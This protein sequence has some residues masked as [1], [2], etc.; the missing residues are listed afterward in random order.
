MQ[1]NPRHMAAALTLP[2]SSTIVP[3][4]LILQGN[5]AEQLSST[6][7]EF[8]ARNPLDPLEPE[9]VL[10]QSNGV[11]EWFRMAMAEHSRICAAAQVELPGRFLWRTYRQ[12]LGLQNVPAQ[13]PVDK[14]AL[15]WRLLRTLPGLVQQSDFAPLA[16]YLQPN[17]PERLWQ[18]AGRLA[19]LFDQYQ[20]YRPDWLGDWADGRNQLHSAQGKGML[21]PGEQLWQPALWRAVLGGLTQ[22]QRQATRPQIHQRALA[23]LQSGAAEPFAP[24]FAQLPRRVVL[25]GMSHVPVPLLELLAAL[26]PYT[27]VILAVPNPCRFHWADAIDGRELLAM[28]RRRHP[29]RNSTH[30]ADLPPESLHA[31]A[32]PLLVAWGRQ[33]RDFVRQLDAFDDAQAMQAKFALPRVDLFDDDKDPHAPWLTQ[34][35]NHIR[36]LDPLQDHHRDELASDDKS[37]VFHSTHSALREVE[38]LYDQ[39]LALLAQPPGNIALAPRDIVVMVPDIEPFAPAIRAVFGQLPRTDARH[40]PWGIAD[41]SARASHPFVGAL[42]WLLRIPQQRCK[43]SE[44]QALLDVPAIAAR[45]QLGEGDAEQL[46]A[47]IASAG[48]RWGLNAAQRADLGLAACDNQNTLD[49]GLQRMLLGYAA[50][51]AQFDGIAAWDDI[52]GLDAELAGV[53]A[54]LLQR[55]RVWADTCQTEAT[56]LEWAD[57]FRR[58]LA[59]F[60]TP[61]NDDDKLLMQALEAALCDWLAA[62]EQAEFDGPLP[63]TIAREAWQQ[64]LDAPHLSQRFRSGGVTFCT[65]MPLRAIP[66]EVVCLLG[67]NDGDY[68]RRSPRS[69]FDLM[70]LP[71]TAR[72]GDRSRQGDDRQLMLEALLSARRVLYISWAGHSARDNSEQPPSV[73]VSQLRDY[74]EAGWGAK[75]LRHRTTEH[76]LQPFSRRYFEGDAKYH[77]Y[78]REWRAAHEVQVPVDNAVPVEAARVPTDAMPVATLARLGSFVRHPA[79]SFLRERLGVVF[80]R[81]EDQIS[82]DESFAVKGLDEYQL[83]TEVLQALDAADAASA[84][85]QEPSDVLRQ[86]LSELR[87]AGRL[88]MAGLGKRAEQALLA[89]LVPVAQEWHAQLEQWCHTAPRIRVTYPYLAGETASINIADS[90]QYTCARGSF[91]QIIS[92]YPS[93]DD[94][95]GPLRSAADGR[96]AVLQRSASRV[97]LKKPAAPKAPMLRPDKFL[98]SWL[99]ALA[100]AACGVKLH[101]V[102]VARDATV[103]WP[104]MNTELAQ[105]VLADVLAVWHDQLQAP[106][107]LPLPLATSLLQ[108]QG[109]DAEIT[110]DGSES[111]QGQPGEAAEPEWERFYPDFE[112]LCADGRFEQ[113]AALLHAPLAQWVSSLQ[114]TRHAAQTTHLDDGDD[115]DDA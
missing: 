58:V 64:A 37:I 84:V 89:E 7:L 24:V 17:E 27:Q 77:T 88:P 75:A 40:I 43:L 76:P 50:G 53:L 100:A 113:L 91:D 115:E 92:G 108:A 72:P 96:V 101:G 35:Q 42:D 29:L 26:A 25:F 13:S 16:Q 48:I 63:L 71:G 3:G 95:I 111:T 28:E 49:F 4:L 2:T 103:T 78:A 114:A 51:S 31:H 81:A 110:Y 30:L 47:W 59:T 11:A 93:L 102:L 41:L 112:S 12:V 68:P 60:A 10:V 18:L 39:L 32:H 105:Q 45:L 74:L 8:L 85:P 82:D 5:R 104:P 54:T 23:A 55:L 107:P 62:C 65:L 56:P 106:A 46:A 99:Q 97:L 79:R 34:V 20:V 87:T 9:V 19:D 70:A 94:W 38:V 83:V 67:M 61:V 52:G 6:V 109:K 1:Q 15:T 14:S 36:D 33:G 90:T 80:E 21:V 22:Q 86:A 57:R 66:F 69:D 73:L 98:A 44:L